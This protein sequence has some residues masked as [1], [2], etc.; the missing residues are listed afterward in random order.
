MATGSTA[1][2]IRSGLSWHGPRGLLVAIAAAVWLAWVVA[3]ANQDSGAV[4]WMALPL[5]VAILVAAVWRGEPGG[6][7]GLD[8]GAWYFEDPARRIDRE[9]GELVVTIDLG[10]WMLLRWQA[11]PAGRTRRCR[12]LALSRGDMSP[13]WHAFR[14]AVYSPR[15]PPAGL[16]AQAPA[17]PPA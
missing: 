2:E 17:D 14:R 3:L 15:P 6:R 13:R 7:I 10:A 9:A 1:F 12:W 8:G 16:S 5:A 4:A 11:A